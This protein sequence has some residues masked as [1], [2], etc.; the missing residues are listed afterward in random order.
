MASKHEPLSVDQAAALREVF[1]RAY[2]DARHYLDWIGK[3]V[4]TEH[5]L[6]GDDR[7]PRDYE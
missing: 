1:F 3:L 7:R 2:P 5:V 4:Y 6:L